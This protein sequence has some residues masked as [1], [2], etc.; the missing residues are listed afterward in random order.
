MKRLW[1][2]IFLA[3]PALAQEVSSVRQGSYDWVCETEAGVHVSGHTR[4]DKA[5]Q[6]CFN[7]AA[8]SGSPP[9]T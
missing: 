1:L 6:R 3:M 8:A 2:L 7:E 9:L 4:Q 5:F